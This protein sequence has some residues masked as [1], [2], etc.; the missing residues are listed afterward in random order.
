MPTKSSY[1]YTRYNNSAAMRMAEFR[2]N[3]VYENPNLKYLTFQNSSII[4]SS[5]LSELVLVHR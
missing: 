3:L 2:P 4:T 5:Y 1:K